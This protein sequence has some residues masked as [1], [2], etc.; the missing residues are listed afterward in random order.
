MQGYLHPLYAQSFS[1]IGEP[2]FLPKSKGWLIKRK[3]PGTPYFDAMGP[4]PLFFCENWNELIY[5]FSP[6]KEELISISLVIPPFSNFDEEKYA[7]YFDIFTSFKDHYIADLSTPVEKII[8]KTRR[9]DIRK[10]KN[11]LIVELQFPPNINIDEW[12]YL[13]TCLIS[14]HRINGFRTFSKFSFEKQLSIPNTHYFRVLQDGLVV[15]GNIYFIQ[16]HIAYAHLSAFT[17]IG[18]DLGAPYAVKG[19][20]MN[21]FQEKIQFI[22]FGGSTGKQ[23][24]RNGL[25]EFKKGWSNRVEK[26]Y[27]CG[28]VLNKDRYQELNQRR[29]KNKTDWFPSYRTNDF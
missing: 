23:N 20:A 8:S 27:F 13:Y 26:S 5:D 29:F 22:N 24:E 2:I 18:Y 6:L 28:K 10:A 15:G 19:F 14:R 7:Q 1:E 11:K 3:I 17:E 21:Y 25:D 9:K 4:Y 12:E 16:D